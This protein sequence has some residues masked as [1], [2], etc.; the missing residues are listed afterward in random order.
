MLKKYFENNWEIIFYLWITRVLVS[1]LMVL[2]GAK[3]EMFLLTIILY[4]VFD[5]I[6]FGLK[7]LSFKKEREQLKNLVSNI[8]HHYYIHELVKRPKSEEG[9]M[10]FDL[11]KLSSQDM[12]REIR[13]NN[14]K[15]KESRE[16]IEEWIHEMKTPI[17]SLKI[18]GESVAD[19]KGFY[20]ELKRLEDILNLSLNYI[21]LDTLEKDY[22][23]ESVNIF[24]SIHEIIIAEK[25]WIREKGITLEINVN[26]KTFIKTDGKWLSFILNQIIINSIKYS[27]NGGSIKIDEEIEDFN[28]ILYIE[29]RG[30]GIPKS[31]L[32]RIF[33]KGFTGS[34]VQRKSASGLGLYLAKRCADKMNVKIDVQ[35]KESE[36]TSFRLSFPVAIEPFN[37]VS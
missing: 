26:S 25:Q 37:T 9:A 29:D 12:V 35:S 8:E 6:Y 31:D 32:P 18:M 30:V 10:Y 20:E 1:V 15:L 3:L 14:E 11:M 36:Y 4:F 33:E 27:K 5:F 17:T 34:G 28:Y 24:D 19:K 13:Y 7:F 16:F 2:S 21:R 22:H 23:V